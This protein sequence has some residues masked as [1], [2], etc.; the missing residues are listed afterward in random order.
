MNDASVV[1]PISMVAELGLG[2]EM[3]RLREQIA[4]W[5]RNCNA[6]MRPALE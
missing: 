3:D 6:D 1:T 5:I 2:S 4:D